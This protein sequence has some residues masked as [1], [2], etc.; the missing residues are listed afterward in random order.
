MN[1]CVY[2][3]NQWRRHGLSITGLTMVILTLVIA[4]FQ[5]ALPATSGFLTADDISRI[6]AVFV[7]VC[8]LGLTT[9]VT[10]ASDLIEKAD[11]KLFKAA[12]HVKHC[13]HSLLPPVRDS[14]NRSLR[15]RGHDNVLPLL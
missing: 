2:L 5:Y 13:L 6:N 10:I 7:K 3:L 8:K 11:K 1:Q 9:T 15:K 14:V 12:L 4:R